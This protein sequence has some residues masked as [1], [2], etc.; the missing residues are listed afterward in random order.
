M[1][2]PYLQVLSAALVAHAQ[3]IVF[4]VFVNKRRQGNQGVLFSRRRRDPKSPSFT[5]AGAMQTLVC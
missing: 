4:R 5:G 1:S 3:A 2:E